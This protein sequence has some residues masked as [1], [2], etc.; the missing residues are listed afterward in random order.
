MSNRLVIALIAIAC[1]APE[2]A[3]LVE[4]DIDPSH[5]QRADLAALGHTFLSRVRPGLWWVRIDPGTGVDERWRSAR[6]PTTSEKLDG[7]PWSGSRR[8]VIARHTDAT[9]MIR[10]TATKMP[11]QGWW[12]DE[13][14]YEEALALAERSDVR[15]LG[16]F[17][18]P[19]VHPLNDIVREHTGA[20]GLHGFELADGNPEYTGYSGLDVGA[21]VFDGGPVAAHVDFGDRLLNTSSTADSHATLVAGTLAGDGTASEDHGGDAF[22]WR[23]MAPEVEIASRTG[24]SSFLSANQIADLIYDDGMDTSNTSL[25]LHTKGQYDTLSA[26]IDATVRGLTVGKPFPSIIAAANNGLGAQYGELRGYYSV[27][28]NA[29][30]ALIVG[31]MYSNHDH[32]WRGSSMGPTWDGR[33]VPQIMAPTDWLTWPPHGRQVSIDYLRF[34]DDSGT[35]GFAIEFDDVADMDGWR[36]VQN[37]SAFDVSGGSLNFV[38]EVVGIAMSPDA[39]GVDSA[40][41]NLEVRMS[42]SEPPDELSAGA[43]F[44]MGNT[45]H[46]GSVWS[47]SARNVWTDVPADGTWEVHTLD[48]GSSGPFEWLRIR[49]YDGSSRAIYG[50]TWDPAEQDNR[51]YEEH[52]QTSS[53]APVV[54]GGVALLLQALTETTGRDLD[55]RPFLSSTIRALIV[56][57]AIDLVHPDEWVV[58]GNTPDTG[59]PVRYGVGPDWAT[60]YG[61]FDIEAAVIA[62]EEGR[63]VEDAVFEGDTRVFFVDVPSG[64]STLTVTL[65]WDDPPADPTADWDA[66]KLVHDLDLLV[67]DGDGF[68]AMPWTLQPPPHEALPST[69]G[70][71]ALDPD[72]DIPDATRGENHLDNLE[73][74]DI[75]S[76]PAGVLRV[77]VTAA[78][79]LPE[80]PW[81]TFSLAASLTLS[82]DSCEV[83]TEQ[84]N[85]IDDDCDGEVDEELA[86]LQEHCDGLDNDCDGTVDEG[87]ECVRD[88][89]CYDDLL[90]CSGSQAC[91][92]DVWDDCVLVADCPPEQDTGDPDTDTDTDTPSDD[93]E[94]PGG[95][96][97]ATGGAVGWVWLMAAAIGWR[98]RRT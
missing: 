24:S 19:P 40:Y 25:A 88:R 10:T 81:Q 68:T 82:V 76:P 93:D 52:G 62:A 58:D 55:E 57:S 29:K 48:L 2:P 85:G 44:E 74:V 21:A 32:R 96:A 6:I 66:I 49:P 80:G 38:S 47:A 18:D 64:T 37:L 5:A 3:W 87:C 91:V 61:R 14:T 77:E 23:G 34:K 65:A 27:L 75:T 59:R 95:C 33:L 51:A 86:D 71:E 17:P 56:D 42:V 26:S 13:L 69:N 7:A 60:G 31:A 90:D 39:L 63:Y 16:R 94:E 41:H 92:D 78:D 46:G 53:A 70:I 67:T 12:S 50:P 83:S 20:E 79:A 84:C 73:R 72:T 43:L 15:W 45:P 11:V 22:Q 36:E 8:V 54:T 30:N 89:P 28:S 1:T 97:C 98:R 4:V 35:V 9:G